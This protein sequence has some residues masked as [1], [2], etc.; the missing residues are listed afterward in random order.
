MEPA[1]ARV[2][3]RTDRECDQHRSDAD[4][5]SEE[6]PDDERAALDRRSHDPQPMAARGDRGHQPVTGAGSEP[7]A[8]IEPAAETETDDREREETR[9]RYERVLFGDQR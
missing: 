5:A 3:Q 7:G 4:L 9:A 6:E 1:Q 8:D 2:R